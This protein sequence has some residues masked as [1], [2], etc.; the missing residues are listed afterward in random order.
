MDGWIDGWSD[1]WMD[2]WLSPIRPQTAIASFLVGSFFLVVQ[3][4]ELQNS[5][6]PFCFIALSREK[7]ALFTSILS[8]KRGGFREKQV[9]NGDILLLYGLQ[10]EEI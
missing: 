10:G 5:F 1:G 4:K 8:H 3:P 2:G 7:C 6:N 9:L